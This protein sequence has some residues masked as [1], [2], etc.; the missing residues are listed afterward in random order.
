MKIPR[1]HGFLTAAL[2]LVFAA[3]VAAGCAGQPDNVGGT[4]AVQRQDRDGS[5][6]ASNDSRAS[7]VATPAVPASV[8]SDASDGTPALDRE[9]PGATGS[10]SGSATEPGMPSQTGPMGRLQKAVEFEGPV[11][12]DR[13]ELGPP[14][15]TAD[16]YDDSV[17]FTV[18]R[19]APGA[20]RTVV[21]LDGIGL[22]LA[23]TPHDGDYVDT[24][25]VP[26]PAGQTVRW[27]AAFAVDP[28]LDGAGYAIGPWTE[29]IVL[30]A[31]AQP[32]YAGVTRAEVITVYPDS[33]WAD[34][35]VSFSEDERRCIQDSIGDDFER[36]MTLPVVSDG[37]ARQ[38]EVAVFGCLSNDKAG[39]LFV[40]ILK[41]DYPEPVGASAEH[42]LTELLARTDLAEVYRHQ[43]RMDG[44][45]EDA[46]VLGFSAD[47]VECLGHASLNDDVP[48]PS[49]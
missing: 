45:G 35:M 28:G 23:E 48:A 9:R 2:V 4:G 30:E 10:E 16:L 27:R 6:S 13:A 21:E 33:L 3:A 44:N 36:V 26:V 12:D 40:A 7:V 17:A 24:F 43:M 15:L 39:R 20:D 19:V 5:A 46:V 47:V 38:H 1:L 37:D 42:C 22:W 14:V 32:P 29:W 11:A 34:L 31:P 49:P 41:A 25:I 18:D 8:G